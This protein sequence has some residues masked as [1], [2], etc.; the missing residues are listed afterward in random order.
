MKRVGRSW[1]LATGVVN[2]K[3]QILLPR[4]R[5][6]VRLFRGDGTARKNKQHGFSISSGSQRSR[7]FEERFGRCERVKESG[8]NW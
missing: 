1:N 8:R 7:E 6:S 2:E 4:F 5:V 3:T